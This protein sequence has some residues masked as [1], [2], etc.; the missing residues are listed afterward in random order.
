MDI[1]LAEGTYQN[2]EQIHFVTD[3][4][5]LKCVDDRMYQEGRGRYILD[6]V[7]LIQK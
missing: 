5:I 4:L 7:G 2:H 1:A 6:Q 3:A